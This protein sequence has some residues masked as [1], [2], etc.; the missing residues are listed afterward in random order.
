MTSIALSLPDANATRKLGNV[1][2]RSLPAGTVLLLEGNLGSGKTTLV[3]GIGEGL[4]IV[5]AIA[6]P[7]F[8]LVNEYLEGRIPLYHLDLYRLEPSEVAALYLE[9]Y[10]DEIENPLGIV[11]IEWAERLEQRPSDYL[12]IR[13]TGAETSDRQV[14][15]KGIG[16]PPIR[17]SELLAMYEPI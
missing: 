1:L 10:W 17:L 5:E 4:G 3:Q 8:T 15:L 12:Q 9:S 11:A 14:Y 13:L 16:Q 7:T 2:G 6:S